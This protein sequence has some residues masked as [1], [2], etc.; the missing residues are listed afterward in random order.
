MSFASPWKGRRFRQIATCGIQLSLLGGTYEKNM[1]ARLFIG[2][3]IFLNV[4]T[5][6]ASP[7]SNGQA[8]DQGLE[9]SLE[10]LLTPYIAAKRFSGTLSYRCGGSPARTKSF[11]LCDRERQIACGPT[12]KYRIGSV[13]KNFTAA[14]ILRLA[15]AGQ[16][17]LSDTV[18]KWVPEYD[19]RNLQLNGHSVTIHHLLSHTGGL[20]S[21]EVTQHLKDNVWRRAVSPLEMVEVLQSQP[22]AFEPGTKFEYSNFGYNLLGLI[23]ARASKNEFETEMSHVFQAAGLRNTGITLAQQAGLAKGYAFY[24]PNQIWYSLYDSDVFKD[25]DLYI[26]NGAGSLH[27]TT[28]DLLHWV[29]SLKNHSVLT[30]ESFALMLKPNLQGYG[31]GWSHTQIGR[32]AVNWHNGILSP[33]GFY[34]EVGFRSDQ[35]FSFA[36]LTNVDVLSI[37]KEAIQDVRDFLAAECRL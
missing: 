22:L 6:T 16:L 4:A 18:A 31:Y 3:A 29:D 15:E 34:S 7:P 25:R 20:P 36:L 37:S 32:T 14:A 9:Q 2:L 13:S 10:Q 8:L 35:D 28:G 21:Y 23:V 19:P 30:S 33:L 12:T 1:M 26:F 27:S 24:V 5:V 17:S 11:G